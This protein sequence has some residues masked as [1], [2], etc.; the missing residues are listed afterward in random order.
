MVYK[1]QEVNYI[2]FEQMNLINDM[3]RIW[4]QL[5]LYTREFM[6]STAGELGDLEVVGARLYQVPRDLYNRLQLFFGPVMAEQFL[7]LFSQNVVI[8]ASLITALKDNNIEAV[9][10]STTRLYQNADE[11]SAFLA[12]MNSYWDEQLWRDLLYRYISMTIDQAVARMGGEYQRDMDIFG[13]IV[14]HNYIMADYMARG[15][16]QNLTVNPQ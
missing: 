9:N 3:R 2:T 6:I 14:T 8:T 16:M 5:A 4:A 15:I 12:Q 1:S 11:I 10:S 13:R 7:T